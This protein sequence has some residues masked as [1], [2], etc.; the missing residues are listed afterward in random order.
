MIHIPFIGNLGAQRRIQTV[1]RIDVTETATDPGA[2][3]RVQLK[4]TD[5][6]GTLLCD[7]RLAAK[8]SRHIEFGTPLHFPNGLY[9]Q[10]SVGAVRGSVTGE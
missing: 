8:E 7:I 9:I 2:E 1:H 3:A 4:D 6:N 5:A 10:V